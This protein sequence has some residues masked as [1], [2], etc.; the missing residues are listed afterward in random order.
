MNQDSTSQI[1]LGT[2]QVLN[3]P[4]WLVDAKLDSR[5]LQTSVLVLCPSAYVTSCKY[6]CCWISFS[7]TIKRSLIIHVLFHLHVVCVNTCKI[8]LEVV[9]KLGSSP[10]FLL[11]PFSFPRIPSLPFFFFPT[12]WLLV[13]IISGK[14]QCVLWFKK[15]LS[16]AKVPVFSSSQ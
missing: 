15:L 5:I 3:N 8:H 16:N 13:K 9:W 4:M 12:Y 14:A 7:P 1:E 10:Q 6:L 2:F 11:F